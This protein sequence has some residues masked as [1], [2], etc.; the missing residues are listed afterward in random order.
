[1]RPAGAET[2]KD[3]WSDPFCGHRHVDDQSVQAKGI[4][5][6]TAEGWS[7][8]RVTSLPILPFRTGHALACGG[9]WAAQY[10]LA[11]KP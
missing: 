1:M 7:S 9:S 10:L 3:L 5:N 2:E 4:K 8:F 11:E 6:K